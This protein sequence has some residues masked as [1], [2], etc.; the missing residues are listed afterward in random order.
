MDIGWRLQ[1]L[2]RAEKEVG[3]ACGGRDCERETTLLTN[4]CRRDAID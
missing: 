3:V 2:Q 4:G 1:W